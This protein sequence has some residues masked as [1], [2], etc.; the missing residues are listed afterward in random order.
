MFLSLE[1]LSTR[2]REE[3]QKKRERMEEWK[4]DRVVFLMGLGNS[5][6]D[7]EAVVIESAATALVVIEALKHYDH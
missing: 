7:I 6:D 1:T 2:S 5:S 3:D 4:K